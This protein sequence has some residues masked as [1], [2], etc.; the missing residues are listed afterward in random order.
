LDICGENDMLNARKW[1]MT[2]LLESQKNKNYT[3]IK[4]DRDMFH[5]Q[6]IVFKNDTANNIQIFIKPP[7]TSQSTL[8]YCASLKLLTL[9]NY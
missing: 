1:I 3:N 8:E 4:N 7:M 2:E 9:R 5:M 6:K